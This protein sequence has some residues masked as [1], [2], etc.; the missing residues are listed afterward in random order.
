MLLPVALAFGGLELSYL[1][2]Q[3]QE[4][5]PHSIMTVQHAGPA[6]MREALQPTAAVFEEVPL[7]LQSCTQTQL[8]ATPSPLSH[9]HL[10]ACD[11]LSTLARKSRAGARRIRPLAPARDVGA[12]LRGRTIRLVQS[13]GGALL[14][15]YVWPLHVRSVRR[16]LDGT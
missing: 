1:L 6:A 12:R 2:D 4:A 14:T 16:K 3:Q 7:H 8:L 5:G 11:P 15:H 9:A 10:A 13:D